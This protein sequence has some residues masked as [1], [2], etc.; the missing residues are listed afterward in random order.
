MPA[1]HCS[2]RSVPSMNWS[3]GIT[4]KTLRCVGCIMASFVGHPCQCRTGMAFD[5]VTDRLTS[6]RQGRLSSSVVENGLDDVADEAAGEPS[7]LMLD[8]VRCEIGVRSQSLDQQLSISTGRPP[9]LRTPARQDQWPPGAAHLP[10]LTPSFSGST[11]LGSS[12]WRS[13]QGAVASIQQEILHLLLSCQEY[14]Q[15]ERS[16]LVQSASIKPPPSCAL[17]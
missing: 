5:V 15:A 12:A 8:R 14:E 13:W 11:E 2:T 9:M 17:C 1:R 10:A 6:R 7:V 16:G 3:P 4:S